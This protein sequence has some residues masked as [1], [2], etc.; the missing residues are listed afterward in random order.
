MAELYEKLLQDSEIKKHELLSKYE[1]Q[2][3]A[4][5][6]KLLKLNIDNAILSM[7]MRKST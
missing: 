6:E 1:E 4:R 2:A 5:D 7:L 3:K